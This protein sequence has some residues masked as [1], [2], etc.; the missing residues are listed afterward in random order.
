MKMEWLRPGKKWARSAKYWA[1]VPRS[2]MFVVLAG[3]FCLFAAFGL[4]ITIINVRHAST[5]FS[6]LMALEA[7]LFGA[8][9]AWAVFRAYL[10]TVIVAAVVHTLAA[11]WIAGVVSRTHVPLT[12]SP[13]GFLNLERRTQTAAFITTFL[14]IAGYSLISEFI[15][16]EGMRVFGAMTELRL[17][18]EIHR[19]LVPPV[20]RTIGQ[21][22]ICGSSAAS[23][24]MG[25]DLVDVIEN[26]NH[27][28]AYVADVSGHGVPAGMIMAMVKSAVR[29]GSVWGE[30]VVA[31]LTN[32][33]RVL[34]SLSAANVFIT[35]AYLVGADNSSVQFALAGHLPILHYRKRLGAVEERSVSNLPLA[36]L[37]DSEFQTA[38]I[39]CEPGDLL[40]VLTD[41]F[42]EVTDSRGEE[43]GLEAFKKALLSNSSAP[44]Q[45]VVSDLHDMASRHGKQ[46]DDQTLL[47]VRRI[48]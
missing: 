2:A 33:N 1:T 37:P 3:I 11:L 24:Q 48:G 38:S 42:T 6:L 32:L 17:A 40:A 41:G 25:G 21:F 44:L 18:T 47:L 23:G 36:V 27:W 29:T 8:I 4:M 34:A 35:L 39:E 45:A 12:A 46:I 20:S 19:A 26:G 22:E 43:L 15:R 31:T 28:T 10:K 13:A 7:G 9:L 5:P 16:K 14:I 30:P